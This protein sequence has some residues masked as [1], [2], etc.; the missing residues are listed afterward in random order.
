MERRMMEVISTVNRKVEKKSI[1]RVVS[2]LQRLSTGGF[3]C[4]TVA[5]TSLFWLSRARRGAG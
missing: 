2:D 5:E 3:R 1:Y 4:H